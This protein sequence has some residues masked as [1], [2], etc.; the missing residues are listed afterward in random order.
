[1]VINTNL[2]A[3]E[4]KESLQA[5]L[6]RGECEVIF[7]KNDGS[8]REMRCTLHPKYLP[9]MEEREGAPKKPPNH[10]VIAV[11][12]LENDAWRSFRIDAIIDGPNLIG[13]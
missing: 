8:E 9:V 13:D 4:L 5:I 7:R 6:R 12:D 2:P 10:G 1:M 3:E 11:W